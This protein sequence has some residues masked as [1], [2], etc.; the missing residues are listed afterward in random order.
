MFG[1]RIRATPGSAILQSS[2]SSFYSSSKSMLF[3]KVAAPKNVSFRRF[4][5]SSLRCFSSSAMATA[6]VE[7]IKV[8]N[9]IVEMD[10]DEMTRII[11]KMIK[12]KLIVP[13]L[14]LDIKYYDLGVL[15]RDATDDRVTVESAEATLKYNVAVKC[16]TITPG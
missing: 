13:F 3:N 2:S 16:A 11:W 8:H 9:P 14:D 4:N 6:S 5:F 1:I 12:D 15:N 10:G 7:R